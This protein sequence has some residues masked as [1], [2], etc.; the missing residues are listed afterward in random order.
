MGFGQE[1]VYHSSLI[2]GGN[3][4]IDRDIDIETGQPSIESIS[5]IDNTP[6]FRTFFSTFTN[7]TTGGEEEGRVVLRRK[8]TLFVRGSHR[9]LESLAKMM[10]EALASEVENKDPI[11][12]R[13]LKELRLQPFILGG[14][15]ELGGIFH[16][17]VF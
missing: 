7:P 4:L 10:F 15:K 11:T 17:L 3:I 1:G 13:G 2:N 5:L 16:L 9:T 6:A 12:G 14:C 8:F